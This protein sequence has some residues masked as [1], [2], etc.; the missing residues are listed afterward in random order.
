M[1]CRLMLKLEAAFSQVSL[2]NASFRFCLAPTTVQ[3]IC[4]N[5]IYLSYPIS[6][7]NTVQR[8]FLDLEFW[9]RKL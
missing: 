9:F 1:L 3:P 7:A 4:E 2:I 8:R 6:E 5:E